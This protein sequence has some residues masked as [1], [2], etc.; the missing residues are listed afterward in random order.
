MENPRTKR[1]TQFEE[2]LRAVEKEG[3][4]G[5]ELTASQI[6][7]AIGDDAS[8]SSPHEVATVIGYHSDSSAVEVTQGSPYRYE[9]H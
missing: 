4:Q 8:V 1:D 7:D 5:E 2:I 9:F 6:Y 3:L